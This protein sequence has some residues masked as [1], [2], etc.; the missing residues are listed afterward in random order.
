MLRDV[1]IIGAGPVG[2]FGAFY[3]GLRGMT[4]RVMDALDE[5]GG[6]L[7]ALYPEKPIYDMPGFPE[8]LAA[9]LVKELARQADRFGPEYVLGETAKTLE[10]TENG[11][12]I[13]TDRG[14]Y[15]TRTIILCAG[16]GAF[17]PTQLGVPREADFLGKGLS[18]GVKNKSDAEGKKCVVVGGGDSACDWALGLLDVASEVTLVHRRDGFRAHEE[19]V[20]QLF[21]SPVKV[22]TFEVVTELIGQDNIEAVKVRNNKDASESLIECDRVVV[23]IGYKSSL[24]PLRD[25][26]LELQKNK[27]VVDTTMRTNIPGVFAAG[28]VCAHDAKLDLIATGVGEVCIA[29]NYAKTFIDPTA[30]TFPG[31][32]SDMDLPQ[33]RG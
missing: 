25:W 3:A 16:L 20:R 4:C 31:H 30:K 10:N 19:T 21:T 13:G 6:Q 5:P 28:D 23:C 9:D 29:V 14:E 17:T 15:D 27:I 8:V 11:F 26:G 7:I 33:L 24:G 32:S 2:L 12:R 1:T 22:R 18:Y